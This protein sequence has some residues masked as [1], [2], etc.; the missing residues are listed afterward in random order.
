[1]FSVRSVPRC[2]K[3]DKLVAEQL[4]GCGSAIVSFCSEELVAETGDSSGTQSKGN[5]RCWKPLPSNSTED[6]TMGI[7]VCV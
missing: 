3:H 6:V 1:V 2:Y 5:V 4:E 7:G